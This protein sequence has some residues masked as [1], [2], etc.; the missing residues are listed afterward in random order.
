VIWNLETPDV[1]GEFAKLKGKGATVVKE[2]YDPGENS[3]DGD[4]DLR[5]SGRQLFPADEPDGRRDDRGS[6]TDGLEAIAR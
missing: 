6:A 2:P 4:H 5:G 3:G 1:E